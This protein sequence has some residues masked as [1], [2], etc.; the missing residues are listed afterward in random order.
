MTFHSRRFS[1]L[2]VLAR[3]KRKEPWPPSVSGTAGSA[4][5]TLTG[6]AAGTGKKH[7]F[8]LHYLTHIVYRAK[9]A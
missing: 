3:A 1:A 5:S 9:H 8:F 6:D 7:S 4:V 2:L